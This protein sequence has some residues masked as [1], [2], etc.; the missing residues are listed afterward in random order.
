MAL[1]D[2]KGQQAVWLFAQKTGAVDTN[3]HSDVRRSIH[4]ISRYGRR[5]PKR[6]SS[7]RQT[8]RR[9]DLQFFQRKHLGVA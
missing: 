3:T 4:H 7:T 2:T 8:L 9:N 6:S 5:I 1:N